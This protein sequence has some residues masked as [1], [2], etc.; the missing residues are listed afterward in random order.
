MIV[1]AS[2]TEGPS[3]M[4]LHDCS[5]AEEAG[6]SPDL[7]RLMTF[8]GCLGRAFKGRR[9]QSKLQGQAAGIQDIGQI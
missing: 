5:A 1:H 3:P 7:S 8:L 4:N 9:R 2:G 6:Q